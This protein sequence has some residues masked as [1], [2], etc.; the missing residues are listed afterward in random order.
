MLNSLASAI[1]SPRL[2]HA[3]LDLDATLAQMSLYEFEIEANHLGKNV[4]LGLENNPLLPGVILTEEG[5][6]LGMISR[7][8]FFEHMS[9]PYALE[10][11]WQRP[12]KTLYR[13]AQTEVLVVPWDTKIVDAARSALE[14]SPQLI[15]EPIVVEKSPDASGKISY[16]LI[17]VHQLMLEQAQIHQRARHLVEELYQKLETVNQELYRLANSDGLTLVANRRRFDEYFDR[18]WR[19]CAREQTPISLILCD[20]DYFKRYNDSCGHL[21]GDDCLRQVAAAI[22][23]GIMRPG[24]LLARYGGEEFAVILPN[25][26]SEGAVTV[27]KRI[28]SHIRELQIPHPASPAKRVTLSLGVATKIPSRLAPASEGS[29]TDLAV[30]PPATPLGAAMLTSGKELLAAADTALYLAKNHGRDRFAVTL[31]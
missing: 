9:R 13:F 25:T 27:A 24:D 28:Q 19:R 16:S 21:A 4:A 3:S 8:R 11:F 15:Y 31:S 30:Q 14:R 17:D 6:F 7:Q 29:Y 5:R 12:V 1:W 23:K 18:E 20:I 10:L 2:G 22:N 26:P